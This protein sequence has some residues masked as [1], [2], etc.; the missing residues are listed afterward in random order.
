MKNTFFLLFFLVCLSSIICGQDIRVAPYLPTQEKQFSELDKITV[1]YP[2]ENMK[3]TKGAKNIFI[4]G[5]VH[6]ENPTS[7]QVNGIDVPL[8]KNGAF[9]AYLPVQSGNF[10]FLLTAKNA[11]ETFSAVRHIIVPGIDI[12]DFSQKASFDKTEVFPQKPVELLPGDTVSLEARGTPNAH[13]TATLNSLKDA[14]NIPLVED[15]KRPGIYRASYVIRS[16]QKPKTSKVTYHMKKGPNN[17][18]AKLVA[19]EKIKVRSRQNPFTYATITM[20]GTKIRKIP[21][22]TENLYPFYRAYG[23][24]L[25]NGRKNG[26]YRIALNN[27]E[28]AWLEESKLKNI[29]EDDYQVNAISQLELSTTPTKTQLKFL[30]SRQV[31]ISV[32]EY[33][34]KLELIVYYSRLGS[35]P[36]MLP[37]NSPLIDKITWTQ[38]TDDTATFV[39]YFKPDQKLWGHDYEFVDNNLLLTLNHAPQL[40]PEKNKPL[41]GARI[42]IDAGH[43]PRRQAPYDGAVGPTG[44][45]EYEANLALAED[46]KPK[47]EKLGATVI[48]TRHDNNRLG[49]V[50]RH[51]LALKEQ[52]HI[53]ISLHYNA[54]PETANPLARPRGYCVY[55]NYPHSFNLAQSVYKGFTKNVKLPDNG[56]IANDVLFIPRIP[57][58]P[59]ILVENAYL[60][61]PEQEEMAKTK[62]GRAPFVKALYEGILNFYGVEEPVVAPKKTQKK[63]ALKPAVLLAPKKPTI[64]PK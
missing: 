23:T 44:Y 49:L 56:M 53:F 7:L 48:L 30:G 36:E 28:S 51:K 58:I 17:S 61:L 25:I 60:I 4:F 29:D 59:S 64:S 57:Q 22:P 24:V 46:L 1:Q 21:T 41:K 16:A 12:K 8:H 6:L 47:L 52:A 27:T 55:Y 63:K 43:S 18:S 32:H 54:L 3:V 15:A 38:Q 31:P 45:L 37:E 62:E 20:D 39:I 42:L 33:K 13:V 14:K 26:Q 10:E 9:V 5:K 35:M 2:H 11:T 50:E 40:T 34:D 19:P